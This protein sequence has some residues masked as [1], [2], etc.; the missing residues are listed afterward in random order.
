MLRTRSPSYSSSTASNITSTR[1]DIDGA[2]SA[3]SW[4]TEVLEQPRN[5][6]REEIQAERARTPAAAAALDKIEA[7]H[8]RK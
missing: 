4:V 8:S 3:P 7:L 2:D 6:F 1:M 5:S